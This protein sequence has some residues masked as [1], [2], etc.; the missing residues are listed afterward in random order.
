MSLLWVEKGL[1]K[2]KE[3]FKKLSFIYQIVNRRW[4][5]KR[6]LEYRHAQAIKYVSARVKVEEVANLPG[7]YVVTYRNEPVSSSDLSKQEARIICN[8][9]IQKKAAQLLDEYIKKNKK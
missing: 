1:E 4:A 3:V 9:T 8:K 6:V 5:K 2:A 7:K